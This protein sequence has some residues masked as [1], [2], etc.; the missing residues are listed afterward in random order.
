MNTKKVLISLL[1]TSMAIAGTLLSSSTRAAV[2]IAGTRVV[3]N[4]S[5]SEVTLKLTNAGKHPALTQVWLDK[6]NPAEDPTKLDLPFLLTP[7]LARIDPEKSQTVR[8]AYTGEELPK[9]RETLLWFNMLE[10]PP[11]PPQ[12]EAGAN[13]V[14]LAFRSRIKFFFRPPGLPGSADDAPGKLT[15]RLV[16]DDGKSALQVS[17]PTPYHVTIIEAKVGNGE[18]APKL[19]EGGMVDPGGQISLPLSAA[20][21]AKGTISFATLN[22]YGGAMQHEA[23]LQ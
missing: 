9:D 22:D 4:A 2:V 23:K 13:Y 5:D 8:I 20:P 15:W 11:K 18:K 19:S 21:A 6:G 7:A 14:Q 12:A 17:N 16:T 3:Y 10:V 1:M